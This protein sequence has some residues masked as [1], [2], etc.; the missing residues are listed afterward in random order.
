MKKIVKIVTIAVFAA[1]V[2][3][4]ASAQYYY[5]SQ[6]YGYPSQMAPA[7]Q[8]VVAPTPIYAHQG[9]YYGMSTA[10]DCQGGG[11][12]GG[13]YVGGGYVGGGCATGGC[14]TGSCGVSYGGGGDCAPCGGGCPLLNIWN[15]RDYWYGPGCSERVID[16]W[17]KTW[18]AC[19]QC[20]IY[21][22]NLNAGPNSLG[23][24]YRGCVLVNHAN[25]QP[26][27][28]QMM[29]SGNQ[30]FQG[31]PMNQTYPTM[32]AYPGGQSMTPTYQAPAKPGCSSC[33]GGMTVTANSPAAPAT[34]VPQ[35]QNVSYRI[36]PSQPQAA[37]PAQPA[38]Q[39]VPVQ[40]M[41]MQAVP[42]QTVPVQTQPVMIQQ[43]PTGGNMIPVMV[44]PPAQQPAV[45]P[46]GGASRRVN[47]HTSY[48]P[49]SAGAQENGGAFQPTAGQGQ[50][51]VFAVNQAP[52]SVPGYIR[53]QQ[54][55][56]TQLGMP[57]MAQPASAAETRSAYKNRPVT[58]EAS[59]AGFQSTP[60][61][62]MPVN[63]VASAPVQ[64]GWVAAPQAGQYFAAQPGQVQ[65]MPISQP[66]QVVQMPPAQIMPVQQSAQ[67]RPMYTQPVYA[68]PAPQA[69]VMMLIP[70]SASQSV[71][72]PSGASSGSGMPVTNTEILPAPAPR[73]MA[74]T[75][76]QTQMVMPENGMMMASG[77]GMENGVIM[78]NDMMMQQMGGMP[79][80]ASCEMPCDP[81]CG[82]P[83]REFTQPCLL[84]GVLKALGCMFSRKP[85]CN[86]MIP[87]GN[88]Q[89]NTMPSYSRT[90]SGAAE[91][92]TA[93]APGN[94]NRGLFTS[95]AD[96]APFNGL[97]TMR[98]GCM[99]AC[100]GQC[101]G[102]CGDCGEMAPDLDNDADLRQMGLDNVASTSSPAVNR[103]SGS[104]LAPRTT[105]FSGRTD[106]L[107]TQSTQRL[108]L[109]D[110]TEVILEHD[111]TRAKRL[112]EQENAAA[113]PVR[114]VSHAAMAAEN[115]V[116]GELAEDAAEMVGVPMNAADTSEYPIVAAEQPQIYLAPGEV[117][118][119]QQDFLLTPPEN[120][121]D[122]QVEPQ[123]E[124]K[125]A[126]MQPRVVKP[127]DKSNVTTVSYEEE[128]Q[129]ASR[130][131]LKPLSQN[132]MNPK[133]GQ[134]LKA[135]TP[136]SR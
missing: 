64:G 119:S 40:T 116:P 3:S 56:K 92:Q 84:P 118:V 96:G 70:V 24:G 47:R 6:G 90:V 75:L 108:T 2:A 94:C 121:P 132:A 127:A 1:S 124:M 9:G 28:V 86:N 134:M 126:R 23:T 65:L 79:C 125:P 71:L 82:P 17:R 31:M 78:E 99:G 105:R 68:Q 67:M 115:S 51:A 91:M 5:G 36:Q 88:A 44:A 46:S 136:I 50:Q 72:T 52:A 48:Y 76:P 7:G 95:M 66:T 45:T 102:M 117:L 49:P 55:A 109:D 19:P 13:G 87:A 129:A 114:Q 135:A 35:M 11:C 131:T 80:D 107:L 74:G 122:F 37:Y 89:L 77:P 32:Q 15:G 25:P 60:V 83:C 41:P 8:A 10:S 14:A 85:A 58:P 57:T 113:A 130:P 73:Q 123:R 34:Y 22:E 29:V 120:S 81:M 43:M 38:V 53:A 26:M 61:N 4:V 42:M 18:A 128:I 27:P 103:T 110:G 39:M 30:S 100:G 101:G 104:H 111:Q 12:G 33:G 133:S 106:A 69:P 20:N 63:A 112:A 54:N 97:F 21:G 62:A 93:Y 59:P 16:E 98:H